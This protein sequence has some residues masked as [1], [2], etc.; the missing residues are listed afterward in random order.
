MSSVVI[1]NTKL[2]S[3]VPGGLGALF[4]TDPSPARRGASFLTDSS[5]LE[6]GVSFLP[7]PEH[8]GIGTLLTDRQTQRKAL[9]SLVLRM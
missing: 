1:K 6:E 2:G 9:P 4:L 8:D 3:G 7:I 5:I